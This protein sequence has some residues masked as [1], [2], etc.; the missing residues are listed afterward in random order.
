MNALVLTLLLTAS[1]PHADCLDT[2]AEALCRERKQAHDDGDFPRMRA[3][4]EREVAAVHASFSGPVTIGALQPRCLP[5]EA[6]FNVCNEWRP[7]DDCEQDY[8]NQYAARGCLEDPAQR[9]RH[10]NMRAMYWHR[11][12][13][14]GRAL[15][16]LRRAESSA[17]GI[18]L[19]QWDEPLRTRALVA[20]VVSMSLRAQ[21]AAS[22]RNVDELRA[23]LL[24]IEL[25]RARLAA[26]GLSGLVAGTL[27]AL[28]WSLLMAREAGLST[29][30]PTPL[31]LSALDGRMHTRPDRQ[32]AD[33][34]RINLALAALQRGDR[35]AVQRW[36]EEIDAGALND[37]GRMWLRLVQI[38]AEIGASEPRATAEWQAE[39][40]A[41]AARGHVVMAR[42]FAA[43]ARGLRMDAVGRPGAAV[44]AYEVAE[45]ELEAY[46]R[47]DAEPGTRADRLY[48]SFSEPTR[49]LVRLLIAIG[50]LDRAM[51]VARNSRSRALR[52]AA[53]AD[54][55][56]AEVVRDGRPA[57][58][59]LRL[60]YFRVSPR[61]DETA[62]TRWAGFAVTQRAVH[63]E[64]IDVAPVPG[65]LHEHADADLQPWSEA[66]LDP[67]GDEIAG[68]TA[69]EIFAT[70]ALHAVPFHALPWDGKQ[71]IDHATV[72]H[73]LDLATCGADSE[74][75]GA[76]LVVSGEDPRLVA[77]AEAVVRVIRAGGRPA[78][79]LLPR[80]PSALEPVLS[81]SHTTLHLAAHG[82]RPW[83]SELLASD[84]RLLLT[85]TLTLARE[86]ILA[87]PRAPALVFLSACQASFTDT[88][89]LG[90]GVGLAHAFLLRG[91]RF[92]VGPVDDINGEVA[93]RFAARFY[94]ELANN[95]LAEVP[96]AWRAAYLA[97]RA[98]LPGDLHPDLR[99]LRLHA[100]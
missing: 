35:K 86:A 45:A 47:S 34:V 28:G 93:G 51:W 100:R 99:M 77:E 8:L 6:G 96:T 26:P 23:N 80:D 9:P 71:L 95:G 41:V 42:W 62:M 78:E 37:E 44:A 92:V 70:D 73:G 25:L 63:V 65:D 49:H 40:D 66:L 5:L 90:G 58:E 55:A 64:Y 60:I 85:D 53:R 11:R 4:I 91:S 81:G 98:A 20:V 52:A 82:E 24:A 75:L 43:W 57:A 94:R 61:T 79:L 22:L 97:T 38:R 16:H 56:E 36:S 7:G 89:T 48:L 3:L 68:A 10:D 74:R 46:A 14:Y 30:D 31:L 17:W 33:D 2:P 59:E 19:T 1:D 27:N 69:I 18:W 39:L 88:E 72:R 87:A 84:D 15:E 67:F 54:C 13:D 12:M 21:I 76:A 83:N 50:D 32:K 29:E